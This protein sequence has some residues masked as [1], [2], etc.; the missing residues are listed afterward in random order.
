MERLCRARRRNYTT[1]GQKTALYLKHAKLAQ[2]T[3]ADD[4]TAD[5]LKTVIQHFLIDQKKKGQFR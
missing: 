2:I 1:A 5:D 4:M 3:K